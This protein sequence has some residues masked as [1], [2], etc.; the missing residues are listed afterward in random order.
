MFEIL[1]IPGKTS[2]HT[3]S[4][5]I[6]HVIRG[7]CVRTASFVPARS[8][9]RVLC[10]GAGRVQATGPSALSLG[11]G[12]VQGNRPSDLFF[13]IFGYRSERARAIANASRTWD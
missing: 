8:I 5:L 6:S 11:R 4:Y 12:P 3:V 7:L 2:R 13:Y 9:A 1:S 10:F